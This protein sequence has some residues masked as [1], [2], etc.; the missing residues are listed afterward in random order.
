M[1]ITQEQPQS[2]T[3]DLNVTQIN[4]H[5]ATGVTISDEQRAE[6]TNKHPRSQPIQNTSEDTQGQ[7]GQ[8]LHNHTDENTRDIVESNVESAANSHSESN[9]HNTVNNNPSIQWTSEYM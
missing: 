3:E 1:G 7:S 4:I 6:I 5:Q 2:Q 8:V 9:L